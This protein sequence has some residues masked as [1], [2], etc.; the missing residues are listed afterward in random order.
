MGLDITIREHK[1]TDEKGFLI[2][3]T[4]SEELPY[5]TDR[6]V[7]RHELSKNI[8]FEVLK[9]NDYYSWE[10]YYRPKDFDEAFKWCDTL[11]GGEYNYVKALLDSLKMDDNYWLEYG[12]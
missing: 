2:M 5:S 12:Y 9:C 4:P 3:K 8:D 7:I 11:K 1:G 6:L 10:E